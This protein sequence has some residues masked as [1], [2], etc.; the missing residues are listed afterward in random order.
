[1]HPSPRLDSLF[2]HHFKEKRQIGKH[3][4]FYLIDTID[5]LVEFQMHDKKAVDL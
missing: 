2:S 4:L 3:K 1:V 5:K